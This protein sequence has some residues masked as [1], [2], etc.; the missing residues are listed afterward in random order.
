MEK[1]LFCNSHH[2]L[3]AFVADAHMGAVENLRL[4]RCLHTNFHEAADSGYFL[5]TDLG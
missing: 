3:L 2:P 4:S 1:S 5:M